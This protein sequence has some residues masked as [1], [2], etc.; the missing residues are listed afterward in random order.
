MSRTN[1][2]QQGRVGLSDHDRSVI[3]F[4]R[5]NPGHDKTGAKTRAIKETLG[6]TATGY[7]Q[8]LNRLTSHPEAHEYDGQ[9]MSR[10]KSTATRTQP[11]RGPQAWGM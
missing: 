11:P 10:V 6:Q 3:D 7:Y 5:Q 1:D 2:F 8:H 9:T 4:E